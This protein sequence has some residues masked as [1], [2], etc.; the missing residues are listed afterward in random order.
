MKSLK[1]FLC[2][3]VAGLFASCGQSGSVR[4]ELQLAEALMSER[5]DSSLQIIYGIDT[6]AL[7]SQ[8]DIALYSLLRTQAEDKNYID[9]K[10]VR[11]IRRAADFYSKGKDEYHKMLSYFYLAR[12][13][14]NAGDYSKAIVELMKAEA[15][16]LDIEDYFYLG[17]I[18]STFSDIYNRVYSNVES[19][20]YARKA[21]DNFLKSGRED[22]ADWEI[23]DIWRAYNNGRDY[24]PA[25]KYAHEIVELAEN[26][27][28]KLLLCE[29]LRSLGMSNLGGGYYH[30]AVNAYSRLLQECPNNVETNDYRNLGVAYVGTSQLDSAMHYMNYVISRDTTESWL[31]FEVNKALGNLPEA[32]R[33]MEREHE[34]QSDILKKVLNQNVTD[35]VIA[36]NEFEQGQKE[37]QLAFERKSKILSISILILVALL[38][39]TILFYRI[40]SY[41]RKVEDTLSLA[42]EL[43]YSLS[44]IKERNANLQS[45]ID[46]LYGQSFRAIDEL[47]SECYTEKNEA[48]IVKKVRTIVRGLKDDRKTIEKLE[49]FV[50]NYSS[51]VMQRFR[52]DFPDLRDIDYRSFLYLATGFSL[53]TIS[54]FVD[55]ELGALYSRKTRL[56]N[57]INKGNSLYKEEYLEMIG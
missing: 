45:A 16:G 55:V 54:V 17:R 2:L 43:Q 29:G 3:F 57:K 41:R 5:P 20:K 32:L 56:K 8:K 19:L 26:K 51:N 46:V 1:L 25:I 9:T 22:Y 10:D 47:C 48:V 6:L 18:Y 52:A 31:S 24:I 37:E 4:E 33:A 27:D 21:Y 38:L 28:D 34:Y 15:A 7:K 30:E 11:I 12:I 42:T 53:R 35:A 36:Y 13:E 44:D 40:K 23:V 50:N 39:I 49:C 14:Q